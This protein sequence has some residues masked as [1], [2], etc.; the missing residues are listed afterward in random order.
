VAF[1]QE[2]VL[3]L[4]DQD[5]EVLAAILD[6]PAATDEHILMARKAQRIR[7][8][9]AGLEIERRMAAYDAS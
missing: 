1:T 8:R 5:P 3:N 2:Q 4:A 7:A 6:N 9:R